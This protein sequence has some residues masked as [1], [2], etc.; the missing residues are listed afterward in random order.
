MICKLLNKTKFVEEYVL[1]RL[2]RSYFLA[3]RGSTLTP[4]VCMH[5]YA[6][7]CGTFLPALRHGLGHS[8]NVFLL[9]WPGQGLGS[10]VKWKITV[11]SYT[12]VD[13]HPFNIS[14]QNQ[15]GAIFY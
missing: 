9:D 3:D 11:T 7:G 2:L 8:R 13:C 1:R 12:F 6:A 4:L 15:C 14:G 5:G 10:T